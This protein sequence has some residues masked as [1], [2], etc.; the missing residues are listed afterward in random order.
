MYKLYNR[1]FREVLP[2]I[3]EEVIIVTDPPYNIGFKYNSYQDNLPYDEYYGMMSRLI[4]NYPCVII[5]YHEIL[6]ELTRYSSITPDKIMEWVY[7]SNMAKQHRGIAYYHV[8]PDLNKVRQPY[9]NPKD[10]RIQKL[11]RNGSNGARS[12]DWWEIPQVKNV[13][14][15]KGVHPC[16]TPLKLMENIIK[17]LPQDYVICDPF[18]GGGTTGIASLRNNRDFIGCE[19]DKLY[20]NEAKAKL[21]GM[22]QL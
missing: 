3:E 13:S 12:Y 8:Q 9:K 14:H 18:M 2:H 20:F 22:L 5:C 21:G 4:R 17:T 11:I 15:E 7:P 6:H 16:P 1:D 10:K 19:I